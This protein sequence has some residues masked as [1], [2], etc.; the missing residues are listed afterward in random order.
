M[1]PRLMQTV[2]LSELHRIRRWHVEH[3]QDHP[4]EY[5]LW[6]AVLT[7]WLMGWVGWLPT[8]ALDAWWAAVPCVLGMLAPGLYVGWRARAHVRHR[9]RCDWL[10][11]P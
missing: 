11:V 4:L 5:Q 10:D 9:L 7:S 2:P 6:D 3:A 8:W 1:V